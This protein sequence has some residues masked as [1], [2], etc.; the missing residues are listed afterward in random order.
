MLRREEGKVLSNSQPETKAGS[1]RLF[2]SFWILRFR[3]GLGRVFQ[4][5][6]IKRRRR[7]NPS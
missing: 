5:V 3:E 7:G 1:R 2:M 6:S 4:K